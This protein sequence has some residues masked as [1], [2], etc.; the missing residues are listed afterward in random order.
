MANSKY[1]NAGLVVSNFN[2]ATSA[3]VSINPTGLTEDEAEK[4]KDFIAFFGEIKNKYQAV[5][6]EGTQLYENRPKQL[7]LAAIRKSNGLQT[8][9]QTASKDFQRRVDDREGKVLEL[10][11]HHFTAREIEGITPAITE[12]DREELAAT[13]TALET[14]KTTL[15]RFIADNPC[16][17]T[18]ILGDI[19]INEFI[20]GQAITFNADA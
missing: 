14:E 19:T 17:D 8:E 20:N 16:Y 4:L 13:I 5:I 15:D 12:S 1:K 6:N 11:K 7:I 2:R 18:S 3:I 10:K 9:I